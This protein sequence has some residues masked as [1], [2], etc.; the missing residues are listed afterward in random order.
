MK[1]LFRIL[2]FTLTLA[3][4]GLAVDNYLEG[5]HANAE[6][7]HQEEQKEPQPTEEE[8]VPKQEEQPSQPV[9]QRTSGIPLYIQTDQE[10]K[11]LPYGT[12]GDRNMA[13][14]G[15][16]LATLAMVGSYYGF[17]STPETLLNW[18]QEDYYVD[19]AGTSWDIFQ[20]FATY[21]DL[22]FL[23]LGDNMEAAVSELEQGH[24]VVVSVKKGLF[25]EVGH[26]M[27]LTG[28][29]DGQFSLND[30]NDDEKKLHNY[31]WFDESIIDGESVNYWSYYL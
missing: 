26:I 25:T 8:N 23:N 31:Q 4:G 7:I 5:K 28:Y 21:H 16:A 22:N 30:P 10:W 14:N 6:L 15:C 13:E 20:D 24:L 2:F 1:K 3:I 11:E 18:A 9:L 19:G 12:D 17:G 29:K 27:L